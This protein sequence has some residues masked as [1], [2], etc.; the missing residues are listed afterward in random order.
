M[1]TD[2]YTWRVEAEVRR[3]LED[4]ARRAGTSVAEVLARITAAWLA[5]QRA[6]RQGDDSEQE[7]L[8]TAARRAAGLIAGGDPARSQRVRETV[9]RRLAERRAR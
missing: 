5:E 3:A 7:R 4:E 8:H 6:A 2:V 1:K 9:R